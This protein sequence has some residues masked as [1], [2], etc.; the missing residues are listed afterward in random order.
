MMPS[1]IKQVALCLT[2][3]SHVAAT[4]HAFTDDVCF[5]E[6][7]PPFLST[8]FLSKYSAL[9]PVEVMH[10]WLFNSENYHDCRAEQVE[11]SQLRLNPGLH[12]FTDHTA[13]AATKHASIVV[14]HPSIGVHDYASSLGANGDMNNLFCVSAFRDESDT[15]YV[16]AQ[17]GA[18][19]QTLN[20]NGKW[21]GSH[22]NRIGQF[23]LQQQTFVDDVGG[24][25]PDD[26][27]R[28]MTGSVYGPVGHGSAGPNG[29]RFVHIVEDKGYYPKLSLSR[30]LA[31]WTTYRLCNREDF[32]TW[33]SKDYNIT[34]ANFL[35]G[36]SDCCMSTYEI[37]DALYLSSRA[38]VVSSPE[39]ESNWGVR[40]TGVFKIDVTKG[41]LQLHAESW[42]SLDDCVTQCWS[43][44]QCPGQIKDVD[45]GFNSTL[46]RGCR[47]NGTDFAQCFGEALTPP[48]NA[49]C[50][51][52]FKQTAT[53][54]HQCRGQVYDSLVSQLEPGVFVAAIPEFGGDNRLMLSTS[55][56]G[57]HFRRPVT[58]MKRAGNP[59]T[60]QEHG[61]PS[62]IFL[63][64]HHY[65]TFVP[66]NGT[67]RLLSWPRYKLFGIRGH[68]NGRQDGE[69][70]LK[71]V[72]AERMFVIHTPE[73]G[74]DGSWYMHVRACSKAT[75]V[76]Q[77]SHP[78]LNSSRY[79]FNVPTP[80]RVT[81]KFRGTALHG[82][83]LSN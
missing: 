25:H 61:S 12:L 79:E 54:S 10:R 34:N 52:Q 81:I 32:M 33:Q 13:V 29:E 21:D 72:A 43:K 48:W 83:Q 42:W 22:V 69:V 82:V 80:V 6:S 17:G 78:S 66:Q 38:S 68:A 4:S 23:D 73:R 71:N 50:V 51:S 24:P 59:F 18:K 76:C 31:N 11:R 60:V 49:S 28:W 70:V 40:S 2:L 19:T 1:T 44:F 27:A 57:I 53:C 46:Y 7:K 75:G 63:D 5:D 30:N 16:A 3:L 65:R 14:M 55:R 36:Q 74:Q 77:H 26:E 15:R 62:P 20:F 8:D 47:G 45:H 41:C 64:G 39:Q 37:N 9:L 67:I 35:L 56:N 58:V